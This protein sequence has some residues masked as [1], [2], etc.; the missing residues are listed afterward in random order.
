Y[1]KRFYFDSCVHDDRALRWL[2]DVT[3]VEQVMLGTDYPFPLGEQVPGESIEALGLADADR[4]RLFH[5][6][7]LEWLG[8]PL[9]RFAPDTTA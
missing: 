2:L 4:T 1:L 8:L 5:G 6:T 3:G 9:H 7:A